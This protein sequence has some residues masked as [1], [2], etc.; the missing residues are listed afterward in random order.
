MRR[1]LV[2]CS[3]VCWAWRDHA[4]GLLSKFA[5]IRNGYGW[6]S[7]T[8]R[9]ASLSISFNI[10]LS[11]STRAGT[12]SLAT[13]AIRYQ[14]F[15]RSLVYIHIV[16]LDFTREHKWLC[17]T[18]LFRSVQNL[19]L[20]HLRCGKYSQLALFVNSFPSLARLELHFG[21]PFVNL[22][23]RDLISSRLSHI[24]SQPLTIVLQLDI[25][26]VPDSSRLIDRLLKS[27]PLLA[28]IRTLILYIQRNTFWG[29]EQLLN[30]CSSLEDLR[31][32][33]QEVYITESVRDLSECINLES[34]S[35]LCIPA[36]RLVSFPNLKRVTYGYKFWQDAAQFLLYA[37]QDLE[38]SPL[39]SHLTQ[40]T[41]D[42]ER[43]FWSKISEED[44]GML[45]ELLTGDKFSHMQAVILPTK[46]SFTCFP[47]LRK[48]G[49]L[50]VRVE[51]F[52]EGS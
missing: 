30:C 43:Y 50:G 10:A 51:S 48:K 1:T 2:I 36:V 16:G 17:R 31:I 19:K 13:F 24:D 49:L 34:E 11:F 23:L 38:A 39:T 28:Q 45:D 21:A 33:L 42:I 29:V 15:L 27:R 25:T 46:R 9:D 3:C 6:P 26:W 7:F 20:S 18:T 44:F 40:I 37:I 41:F 8:T 47:R 4:G 35:Y 22:E 14:S 32:Y 12:M 5:R 52:W